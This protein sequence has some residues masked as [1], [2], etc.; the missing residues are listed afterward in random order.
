M[1]IKESIK[2]SFEDDKIKLLYRYEASK[3]VFLF[4]S[5]LFFISFFLAWAWYHRDFF[6]Y[7]FSFLYILVLFNLNIF[8]YLYCKNKFYWKIKWNCGILLYVLLFI[9]TVSMIFPILYEW[10]IVWFSSDFLGMDEVFNNTIDDMKNEPLMTAILRLY[11]PGWLSTGKS[12]RV[13]LSTANRCLRANTS[14]SPLSIAT[15]SLNPC[16]CAAD[17]SSPFALASCTSI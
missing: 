6:I 2:K 16:S 15:S 4:V 5:L 12:I 10:W 13:F 9:L 17:N 8:I 1:W 14:L 3:M 11:M 7:I